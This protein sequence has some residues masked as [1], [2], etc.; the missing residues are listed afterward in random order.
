MIFSNIKK[1][2]RGDTIVEVLIAAAVVSMVLVG[3]F[4]IANASAKQIRMSQERSEAQKLAQGAAEAMG[5]LAISNPTLLSPTPPAAFCPVVNTTAPY[6]PPITIA[7]LPNPVC[8]KNN[9]YTISITRLTSPVF[10]IRVNWVG[11]NGAN[12]EVSIRYHVR[13]LAP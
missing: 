6:I 8:T 1:Q 12:E 3:A 7:L 4:T 11:V 10:D 9:I 2:Q 5:Q 13:V